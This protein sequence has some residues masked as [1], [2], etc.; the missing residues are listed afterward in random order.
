MESEQ[1][2]E[3][4]PPPRKWRRRVKRTA[5]LLAVVFLAMVVTLSA[6]AW[7]GIGKRA[8][9]DRL[10]RMKSSPQW[11]GRTF[12]NPEPMTNYFGRMVREMLD[13]SEFADPQVPLAFDR[14]DSERFADAPESG[15][16]ITWLAHSTVLVEIDGV[17][18][19]T[20]PVW[21]PRASPISWLGPER[22]YAPLVS[23]DDLPPIDGVL[24]S[25]DHYDHL[26][27]VT[28]R[29][30]AD[31]DT[32]FFCPLGVG[33]HLEYWGVPADRIVEMDWWDA[34]PLG[35]IT[36]H[37]VP[38]RHASGRQLLDQYRTLWAGFALVGPD[39]RVL[40]S[41]DTGF[42]S[43][44]RDIGERLGPFDVT[45]MEVGAYAQAW[46]DWHLGPE[47]AI[48][49]HRLLRGELFLPVHWGLFNLAPHG[50]TE[51]IERVIVEAERLEVPIAIPLPGKSFEPAISVPNQRWWPERPWRPVDEYPIEAGGLL[52]E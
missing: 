39:H 18:V 37:A 26:D 9:G 40:F 1:E 28:I 23:L 5:G 29:E 3:P 13:S 44:M 48:E 30:I 15:L 25:H 42:F 12:V 47:Q 38:S 36:V 50:W 45:M 24:I 32:T 8:A 16:R 21:G 43:A 51:P 4:S 10:D 52:V 33:A 20:D 17:R 6:L 7:V 46:P 2:P 34:A 11:G 22:W 41:G 49:A 35:G 14:V 27:H 19:L 31:W